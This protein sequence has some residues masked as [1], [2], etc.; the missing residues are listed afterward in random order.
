MTRLS[1]KR[2]VVTGAGR[3]IGKQVALMMAGAGAEVL[4]VD[5]N[6]QSLIFLEEQATGK[7][8]RLHTH[9]ADLTNPQSVRLLAEQ[10]GSTL[11]DVQILVNAAAIVVF[12]WIE[13]LSFTDWK[14][15]LAGEID[16]VFLVT[17][18]LWPFLKTQGGSIINFSS[19]NAHVALAV[20][21]VCLFGYHGFDFELP[22]H[23]GLRLF[24]LLQL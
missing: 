2:A 7:G 19:A 10:A 5:I 21:R 24:S 16:S 23:A 11:G 9:A 17:Q 13:T 14:K 15:T 20:C 18:A 6:E 8:L 3:G 4:A 22:R 12:D 1:G